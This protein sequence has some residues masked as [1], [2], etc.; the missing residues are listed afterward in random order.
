MKKN[1]LTVALLAMAVAT[2][3]NKELDAVTSVTEGDSPKGEPVTISIGVTTG[4][5][6]ATSAGA[7]EQINS[8]QAF[9]FGSSGLEASAYFH[10][11]KATI[12]CNS[13]LKT[14]AACVNYKEIPTADISSPEDLGKIVTDLSD[15]TVSSF[16]MYGTLSTTV[17]NSDIFVVPVSR[18]V[19][20]VVLRSLKNEM[21][22]A[23]VDGTV[24]IKDIFLNDAFGESPLVPYSTFT[25]DVWYNKTFLQELNTVDLLNEKNMSIDIDRGKTYDTRH[26]LYC[27]PNPTEVDDDNTL[28][29]IPRYTRLVIHAEVDGYLGYYSVDIPQAKA[30]H[31]YVIDLTVKDMPFLTPDRGGNVL[32]DQV[33]VTVLGW[34]ESVI[35]AER[36]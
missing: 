29:W 9:I 32:R 13:G 34:D 26:Y 33:S 16:I 27:Y 20:R 21:R 23:I 12:Q 11:T 4:S 6:R 2:S 7:E 1:I 31:S 19:A 35:E 14:I 18:L 28:M 10:D 24:H 8:V 25:T 5:T 15:N 22:E 17:T 36:S 3:C 30:N